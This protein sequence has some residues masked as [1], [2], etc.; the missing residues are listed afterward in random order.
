M[1]TLKKKNNKNINNCH[2]SAVVLICSFVLLL[3]HY[4]NLAPMDCQQKSICQLHLVQRAITGFLHNNKNKKITFHSILS[5]LHWLPDCNKID[6][7][8]LY[9]TFSSLTFTTVCFYL[10]TF[11]EPHSTFWTSKI[12]ISVCLFTP[13]RLLVKVSLLYSLFFFFFPIVWL[14]GTSIYREMYYAIYSCS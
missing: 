12:Q 14:Y 2:Y 1:T 4:C 5:D 9:M 7:M 10:L 11:N 3:P 8:G 13:T 6:F